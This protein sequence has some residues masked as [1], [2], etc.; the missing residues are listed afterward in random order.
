ME[1]NAIDS[2][3]DVSRRASHL[4]HDGATV[5]ALAASSLN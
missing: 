5:A 2:A 1:G 3:D 4:G